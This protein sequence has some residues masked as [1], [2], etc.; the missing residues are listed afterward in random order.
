MRKTSDNI[1]EFGRISQRFTVHE[2]PYISPQLWFTASILL[3]RR[4]RTTLEFELLTI[5][6]F[7]SPLSV[8]VNL[9]YCG[10]R[11]QYVK[12]AWPLPL[13]LITNYSLREATE[14][15]AIL[16]YAQR[17]TES[18]GLIIQPTEFGQAHH[19]EASTSSTPA[20]TL[21]IES[22]D[23]ISRARI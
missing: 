14:H 21:T 13:G 22:L 9:R 8:V 2:D 6:V 12:S 18:A 16:A 20:F 7:I 15:H 5:G 3:K 1:L 10:W 4:L 11:C 23:A 17:A 19:W